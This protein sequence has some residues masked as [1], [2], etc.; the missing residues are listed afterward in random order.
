MNR[1]TVTEEQIE[2][3]FSKM[4]IDAF[5]RGSKTTVIVA[6][7]E[8][9]FVITEFSSCVDPKN[10]DHEVGK[11]LCLDRIKSKIWELEGYRLQVEIS[12]K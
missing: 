10:Y 12:K 5:R 3:I 4:K 9:G 1:N 7:L 11:A 6:E 2:D 8:C